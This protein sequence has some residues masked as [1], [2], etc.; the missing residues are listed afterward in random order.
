MYQPNE[1]ELALWETTRSILSAWKG[2]PPKKEALCDAVHPD[3]RGEYYDL[4]EGW[5]SQGRLAVSS[6]EGIALPGQLGYVAGRVQRNARGFAFLV[7]P[8]SDEDYFISPTNQGGAMNGDIVLAQ[9]MNRVREGMRKECRVTKIVTRVNQQ[10]VGTYKADFRGA[11]CVISDDARLGAVVY[12]PARETGAAKDGMKVVA[13]ITRYP[14]ER[15]TDCGGF[16]SQVLG[17]PGDKGV[18]ITAIVKAM[19]IR[20]EFPEA[21]LAEADR[22]PQSVQPGQ[23]M[24]RTDWRGTPIVTIDG[25]D[26][27]DFDDAVSLEQLE[28][29]QMRLGVHIADVSEYVTRGSQLDQEALERGT[30]VYLLDRVI[31]MLPEALSNGICSLNPQVD[32]LAL[33][34]VMDI[35]SQGEVTHYQMQESVIRSTR[36]MTYREVNLILEKQDQE[37]CDKY[38]EL[39]PLF[40]RMQI[41]AQWL[42]GRRKR[43]GAL[44]LD[45]PEPQILLDEEGHATDIVIHER[46]V[47]NRMI[48]EFMLVANETVASWLDGMEIPTIYR[49]HEQPDPE[50]MQ[51][52]DAFVQPFGYRVRGLNKGVTP[53]N[54]QQLLEK[55]EGQ[56]CQAVVNRVVLRSLQ[57]ARYAPQN[58]GHFG[59]A[60]TDYCHFTSPIRRYPDLS[61]HRSV[62]AVLRGQADA[63]WVQQMGAS[64]PAIALQS[65]ER[66]IAAVKCERE[67][68]DLKMAEYMQRYVG[69]SFEGVISGVTEF[70][71]FV[72]L[73]NTVEGL[74]RMSSME[75]DFYDY[76]EKSYSL[77]G[78][79][80]GRQYHLGDPVTVIVAKADTVS[81]QI[82]FA[83][84]NKK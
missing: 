69:E 37:T 30:S 31:P 80:T 36:R 25:D 67:V 7:Q 45:I 22:I 9:P 8:D 76:D 58:L 4:L 43:R 13:Q 17:A 10:V 55:L 52:L 40:Q 84:D 28:D 75:D 35:N 77:K 65:S 66:E 60:A 16:I 41:L 44:D 68:D 2:A 29:G 48:E 38:R 49:V 23:I 72:E 59:L 56:S 14:N 71:L 27:K 39:V 79:R 70:G 3:H 12:I 19:G 20:D 33:S 21:V 83:L 6:K 5:L 46:G 64:M 47:S 24:G 74:I 51:D 15:H 62:K 57:K 42:E 26:S 34:C 54:L 32:R 81:R 82:D 11:G 53:K 73:P 50:K 63:R 78:R 18:D 1:K 61:V